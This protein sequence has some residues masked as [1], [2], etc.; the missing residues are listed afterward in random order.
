MAR[1]VAVYITSEVTLDPSLRFMSGGLGEVAGG[2]SRSA[3]ALDLPVV[4]VSL[5][6][7]E[8]YGEQVLGKN[9]MEI[10]Y[11]RRK[12][13]H[14]LKRTGVQCEIRIDGDRVMADIWYLPPGKFG[15]MPFYFLDTDI[16]ANN[17]LGRINT[18]QLYGGSSM[19]GRTM[20]RMI[21]QSVVLGV[22]AVAAMQ[23]VGIEPFVY[24]L[25]ESHAVFTPLYLLYLELLKG[26]ELEHAL[27]IVRE[28]IVFTNHT[29]VGAGNPRYDLESVLVHSGF[30]GV[31]SE[32]LLQ[33]L[34]GSTWFDSTLACLRLARD[35]NAVS[36]R[37]LEI[38]L[39]RWGEL[40]ECARW[41]AVTNG[42]TPEFWQSRDLAAA[43]R[44]GALAAAKAKHKNDMLFYI[45]GRTSKRFSPDV[46]TVGW[47]RR[48][49][50]YKRPK[51][52]FRNMDWLKRYLDNNHL[53]IVMGGMPHPDEQE[54]VDEWNSLY[55]LSRDFENFAL[56]YGYNPAMSKIV[57]SG[58]DLWLA[59]PRSPF[60]ACSTS[61]ISAPMCGCNVMSTPDGFAW[62]IERAGR[63]I[64]L[65]G[66]SVPSGMFEQD[67]F[68]AQELRRV[69]D[70]EVIPEFYSHKSSWYDRALRMKRIAENL[71][72]SKRMTEDYWK[73]Y[74]KV[75]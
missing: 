14:A 35:A 60:E 69:M 68:D 30:G 33:R 72:S 75:L 56:L 54:M 63:P 15:S 2:I 59:S 61:V 45:E 66:T 71:Y 23:A 28:Q 16:D 41:R 17:Y 27:E 34:G 25:N 48:F 10:A 70:E 49:T 55:K 4:G 44:V 29:P 37:H 50:A 21:C 36:K 57:K 58:C 53:Q 20:D 65:Y 31:I 62:E 24:H 22:G 1:K 12:Y 6:Y 46:L 3:Y 18:Q 42:V 39:E 11:V 5:L 51:L 47:F 67:A 40:S 32:G 26:V 19:T 9:G 8:G 74:N 43:D 52:L 38:C 13:E 73:L 7:K 64:F